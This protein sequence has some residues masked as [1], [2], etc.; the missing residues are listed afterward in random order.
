M[1]VE[2]MSGSI[3]DSTAQALVNPVNTVGVMGKGLAKEFKRRWPDMFESYK[4]ACDAGQLQV[5]KLHLFEAHPDGALGP[6]FIINLPTKRHWRDRSLERHVVHGVAALVVTLAELALPSVAIP[7]LGCGEGG[8]QWNRVWPLIE[9][10]FR[11]LPEVHVELY[12]PRR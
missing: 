3:F 11:H 12:P 4:A 6:R 8:L 7:A 1:T 10:E 2:L 9:A 5:G